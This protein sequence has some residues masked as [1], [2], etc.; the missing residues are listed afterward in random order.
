M[1]TW[2]DLIREI[3][4]STPDAQAVGA[5]PQDFV[6]RKYLALAAAHTGRAVIL[7]AT[8]WTIPGGS[9]LSPDLISITNQDVHGFM[10]A[11]YGTENDKLDLILHSP[12]GSATAAEAVVNYLRSKF[13]HIRVVV[14]HMAMSAATMISCAAD[15]IILAKHSSLGPIDPQ[16]SLNTAMGARSV[17][18]QAI[19]E[20][21][22]MAQKECQDPSKIRAWLPMLNQYGPDLLVSCQNASRLSEE[23]VKKW[24]ACY[25][26]KGEQDAEAKAARIAEWL[27]KH[28]NHFTHG[29]TLSRDTLKQQGLKIIDLEDDQL[30]QDYYLSVFHA[31]SHTFSQTPAVK[32]IENQK[33]KAFLNMAGQQLQIIQGP[34]G[35]AALEIGLLPGQA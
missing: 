11:V 27:A 2:G 7:Y 19:L 12:G 23:L 4:D 32:I 25:M 16:I 21:F 31:T 33:G 18:A 22:A 24:L 29:R 3:N 8:K 6:R 5:S 20:Q 26:F 35:P 14:P 15:E 13:N 17:P 30:L 10:E 34:P 9:G 28:E 1:P